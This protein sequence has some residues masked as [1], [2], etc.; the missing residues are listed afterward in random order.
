MRLLVGLLVLAPLLAARPIPAGT[1]GP[2]A[3]APASRW[4]R[5]AEPRTFGSTNLYEY[6]DGAADLF[7]GYGFVSLT[8]TEYR[9]GEDE[10]H[11]ITVDVYDMGT[12]LHAFGVFASERAEGAKALDLGAQSYSD[13][14]L[15][16]FWQGQYYV[17]VSQTSED[18]TEA[19]IAQAKAASTRL[20]HA[21]SLPPE[22]S[23][24][25]AED[26]VPGSE[27]YY[28][29]SAL[30]HKFLVET[31]SATYRRGRTTAELYIADLGSLEKASEGLAKL[32]T[33]E[34]DAGKDLK[35][36]PRLGESAFGVRDSSLGEMVAV[37][38][39]R[40]LVIGTSTSASR[41]V[42]TRFVT[43]ALKG[44]EGKPGPRPGAP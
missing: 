23:R 4:E 31:L 27:R 38:H 8:A 2:A 10:E 5:K 40:Y 7:L 36:L 42:V 37:R 17:K 39:G 35:D 26:R 30:G 9:R 44:L 34:S 22:L 24:L 13:A 11:Q 32:R 29:T 3:P 14:G 12:P 15:V 28:R 20:P 25:P 19:A 6:I 21:T 16:A 18:D 33:F 43:P 41:T 1:A